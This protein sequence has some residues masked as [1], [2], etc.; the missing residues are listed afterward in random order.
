M[1]D[2]LTRLFDTTG[3]PPRWHCGEWSNGHGWL[4]IVSDLAVWGAYFAIPC[5]LAYFVLRRRNVP[6]PS[7]FWLFVAFILACG[8]THLMEA[9][10]F[11]HPLYRLAGVIKL[12][13]A[14]ISWVTI[15]ALVPA[16]PKALAMR[17]PEDLEEE[18]VARKKAEH[19]LQQA[20]ACLEA[21]LTERHRAE[22]ALREAS[23][24]KDEFLAMLGHELRNPLVP[25]TNILDRLRLHEAPPE[26]R[27]AY[28][29]DMID[30][31]ICH[32][33]RIVDDLLDVARIS[34]GVIQLRKEV[35]DCAE[36]VREAVEACEPRI[37]ARDQELSVACPMRS[38]WLQADA[39]RL[40]QVLG[41]LL[42]NA[43]KYTPRGGRIWLTVERDGAAVVLRVRDN[44]AGIAPDMLNKIFDMFVQSERQLDRSEGGLGLGLFL[45]RRLVEMHNGTVHATSAGLGEGS[46]FIVRLPAAVEAPQAAPPVTRFAAKVGDRH[47]RVLFVDD[48]AVIVETMGDLLRDMGYEVRVAHSG[49]EALEVSAGF[50]PEAVLLDIGMPGMNGY[51]VARQMRA[52]PETEHASLVAITGYGQEDDRQR[53]HEAGFDEHLTKPVRAADLQRVLNAV[54]SEPAR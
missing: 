3:F 22:E 2:F 16:I 47:M 34:R 19:A 45:V 43:S 18:I 7:I 44:G 20:N 1:L 28:A 13:T 41:N 6:F 50:R 32:L 52:R 38:L 33:T 40:A 4:H 12:C 26:G 37:D 17:S 54:R 53:A 10:I 36:V 30:R 46:E 49:R 48:D 5:I 39:S 51:E 15:V 25:I 27:T 11:W 42:D 14:I 29:L 8:T 35:I 21:D 31:Q 24:H 23:R 9:I